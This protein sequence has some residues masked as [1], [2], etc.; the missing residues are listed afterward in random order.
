[1]KRIKRYVLDSYAVLAYLEGERGGEKVSSI[2][3]EALSGKV[4]I[5][6]SVINW[7]EVYYIVLREQGSAIANL[8]LQ[9]MEKYPIEI[10]GVEREL[11]LG[12][13]Q[14]KAFNRLS[15]ADAFAAALAQMK[16]A[17]LVTGDKEFDVLKRTVNIFWL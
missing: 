2:L 9:T 7:G 4:E 10:V 3:K 1:M 12:A 6:M 13:A 11:T 17:Y 8:Y 14:I 16:K 15:Y 5:Y